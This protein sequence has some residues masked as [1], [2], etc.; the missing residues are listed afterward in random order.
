MIAFK[1]LLS[2]TEYREYHTKLETILNELSSQLKSIPLKKIRGIMGLPANW[3][4]LR[5]L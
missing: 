2:D 5:N 4:K 3:R 1:L